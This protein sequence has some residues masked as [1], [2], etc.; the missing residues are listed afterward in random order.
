MRLDL[1]FDLQQQVANNPDESEAF[2]I[3]SIVG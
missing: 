1:D 3:N 2:K